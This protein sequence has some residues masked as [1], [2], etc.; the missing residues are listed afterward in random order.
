[1][2]IAYREEDGQLQHLDGKRIGVIGY[3][4]LG[5]P[6][7]L[8]LRDSGVDIML[9]TRNDQTRLTAEA[10]GLA[11]TN[12]D[13]VVQQSQIVLMM[14][15]NEVMPAVYLEQ[16]SPHLRRGHSLIFSSGYNITYRFI[17]PPPFVDVGLIAPRIMGP[18]V[19]EKYLSA[20]GYGSFVSV[21]QDSSGQS[22]N[23]VLA[24]AR[25]MGALKVGAIE[26]SFEQETELD[27]FSQQTLIP[28]IHHLIKT[29][30]DVLLARGYP[31][32]AV[33]TE[34]YTSGGLAYY[35]D[36]VTR[37]GLLKTLAETSLT[38]Q[39]G[40]ISRMDRYYDLKLER[41]METALKE[42]HSGEF[43]R[44]WSKEF[45]DGN[46]RLKS[47][48]KTQEKLELW[49]L[50]QQSLDMLGRDEEREG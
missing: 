10:D 34:L 3:G 30:V 15:P 46:R 31:P 48:Y 25:A 44:E 35:F 19:R 36:R 20:E 21:G 50:E 2:T 17:E 5:R 38:D 39:Y 1:M 4:D 16:I 8:N 12:I 14:L 40:A 24:V 23:T 33:F 13:D 28:A 6:V 26:V 42:I 49:E 9:G 29:A 32:D 18:G 7:A 27:L 22:W 47:F 11:A 37:R 41:Q 45:T 43:A